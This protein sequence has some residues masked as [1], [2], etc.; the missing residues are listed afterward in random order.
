MKARFPSDM[1][2]GRLETWFN[3]FAPFY[4]CANLYVLMMLLAM[5]SWVVWREQLGRAAFWLGVLI[6]VAP[7]VGAPRIIAAAGEI[8]FALGIG[9]DEP[10]RQYS[11]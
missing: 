6:A 11:E 7:Q 5:L 4:Q 3:H 2:S 1:S 9:L 10:E 8:A